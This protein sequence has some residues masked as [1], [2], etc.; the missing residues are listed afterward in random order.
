MA[1][2]VTF[3][4][5]TT[6][7]GDRG[8]SG[9]VF[10]ERRSKGSPIFHAVG[11]LD[12]LNAHIGYLRQFKL[13]SETRMFLRKIQTNLWKAMG[14]ISAD[15]THDDYS[16]ITHIEESEIEKLEEEEH[17]LLSQLFIGNEFVT[18]GDSGG[19]RAAYCHIARTA[20]RTCE[21]AIVAHISAGD[22]VADYHDLY[23]VQRYINRLSDYF[24][25]LSRI[26]A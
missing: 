2:E 21:R 24:F 11:E 23:L 20:A 14:T 6:R 9:L 26:Y 5:V 19:F 4:S 22:V 3:D 12:S 16:M 13:G 1:E 25:V 10:G 18:P 7:G 17:R 8:Q 15:K